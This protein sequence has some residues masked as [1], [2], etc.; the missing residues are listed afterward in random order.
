ML[1]TIIIVAMMSGFV[2]LAIGIFVAVTE[3]LNR[4]A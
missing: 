4:G 2:G 1:R 3:L